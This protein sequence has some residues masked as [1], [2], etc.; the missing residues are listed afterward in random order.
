MDVVKLQN[1]IEIRSI[2]ADSFLELSAEHAKSIFDESQYFYRPQQHYS[3]DE[4]KKIESLK[5]NMG[6]PFRL[7]LGAF[8]NGEL[9]GWSWGIQESAEVLYVVNSAVL[10]QFRRKGV[11]SGLIE[12]MTREVARQG[13][14]IIYSRHVA[15]NNAV[16]IPKLKAEFIISSFEISDQYGVLVHLR[17]YA[18]P[19]RRKMLAFRAG[20]I[21]PD[22]Q[23]KALIDRG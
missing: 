13:F 9:A 21:A 12:K 19:L 15:T 18:N 14:Q 23:L 7:Y 6:Q 16:L 2:T 20:G 11:N 8:H 10:P 17:W 5:Q 3:D 1:G 4:T 22:D